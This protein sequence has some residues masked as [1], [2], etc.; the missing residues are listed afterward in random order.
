M[1]LINEENQPIDARQEDVMTKRFIEFCTIRDDYFL[2]TNLL[3]DVITTELYTFDIGGKKFEIPAGMYLLCGCA[4]GSQDWIQTEAIIGR[5][6]DVVVMCDQYKRWN[7]VTPEFVSSRVGT[8]YYPSTKQPVPLI[9]PT[10]KSILISSPIDL[11]QKMKDKPF[12]VFFIV[13]D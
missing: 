8:V 10:G 13:G 3:W 9:D 6:I 4:S 11:H 7:L 12:D 2:V 1:F 5:P